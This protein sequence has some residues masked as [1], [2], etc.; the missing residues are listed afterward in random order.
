MYRSVYLVFLSFA[1][2]I[3]CVPG[4]YKIPGANSVPS[5][6]LSLATSAPT[7]TLELSPDD[8]VPTPV[9][10]LGSETRWLESESQ[11]SILFELP[12]P[13]IGQDIYWIKPNGEPPAKLINVSDAIDH[14]V[15]SPDGKVLAIHTSKPVGIY[16]ESLMLL[17]IQEGNVLT[18]EQ[19]THISS[20]VWSPDGKTLVYARWPRD[21]YMQI[22]GY[23]VYNSMSRVIAD[24]T[25]LGIWYVEGWGQSDKLLLFHLAGGGKLFDEIALLDTVG[26]GMEITYNDPDKML[27]HGILAPDG[28][29]VVFS[30]LLQFGK[31]DSELYLLDL[32]SREVKLL[33][34]AVTAHGTSVSVPVWS[35]DSAYLAVTM[36]EPDGVKGR[37][38]P[39]RLVII[40]VDTGEI[41]VVT[42]VKSPPMLVYPLA[43]LSDRVLLVNNLG[44]EKLDMVLYSIH[45]DGSG[46]QKISPGRFLTT[47][48][49]ISAQSP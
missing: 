1:L 23:D 49:F 12:S 38:S 18:L 31:V 36:G 24:F 44:G 4:S 37:Q 15:A 25:S 16:N 42:E 29:K 22:V 45:V 46:M 40:K 35:P 39:L 27:G 34:P 5:P 7:P 26:R 11:S 41:S 33:L 8:S 30:R 6:E 21:G 9:P 43:W 28:R 3:A 10:T 48:P 17:F 14:A 2:L 47:L 13:V 19:N 32:A 20:I